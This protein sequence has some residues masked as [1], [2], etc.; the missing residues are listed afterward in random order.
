MKYTHVQSTSRNTA[1][2]DP[3]VLYSTSTTRLVF[4]PTLVNNPSNPQAS[5]NG[6]ILYQ[7]KSSKGDWED[8]KEFNLS[9]MKS[10]EGVHL[11]LHAQSLLNLYEALG[12]LYSIHKSEGIPYGTKK[13]VQATPILE[14][15]ATMKKSELMKLVSAKGQIG[16]EAVTRLLNWAVQVDSLGE[17]LG[18]LEAADPKALQK[19]NTLVSITSLTE[20]VKKSKSML[21]ESDE[22][23]WQ[24]FLTSNTFFLEQLF[25][26]PV[27]LVKG[28]AYVGGKSI[29]NKGG[30]VADFL[31]KNSLTHQA[32]LVEIKTPTAALLK[33][34]YRG[35]IH[36]VSDDLT[37]A[38][39]QVLNY[40][41]SLTRE[42]DS[43]AR[44]YSGTLDACD[45]PC[46]VLIGN[47][48]RELTDH[49]KKKSFELFRR[50]SS[51]VQI[52]TYDELIQ[53]TER[54]IEVLGPA[55]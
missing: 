15:L 17:V 52:I 19:I 49:S 38:V 24:T 2:C 7:R 22:E 23:K 28:K 36:N 30:N 37:G 20:A 50:Q 39:L 4:L 54:M 25:S 35:G 34:K 53:K 16:I 6:E 3:V 33:G 13:F 26:V 32:A 14:E 9:K 5:V 10:G 43:I 8:L 21:L 12:G 11:N 42:F 1:D 40:K 41:E 48:K 47:A 51:H 55:K 27:I 18:N 44:E 31:L 29:S 45:P 46:F